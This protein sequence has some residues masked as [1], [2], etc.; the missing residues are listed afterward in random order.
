MPGHAPMHCCM[1][2]FSPGLV[3]QALNE[4]DLQLCSLMASSPLQDQLLYLPV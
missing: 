2:D 3:S 4:F 1:Q